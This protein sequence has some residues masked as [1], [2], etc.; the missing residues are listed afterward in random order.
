ML[1]AFRPANPASFAW[2]YG[3][4]LAQTMC[5]WVVFLYVLPTLIVSKQ[6][7]LPWDLT[8]AAQ[9]VLGGLLFALVSPIGLW[10]GYTMARD[11]EGT[12][13]PPDCPNRLVVRG[14]YS[15]VRNPMAFAGILQGGAV[16]I[17]LGSGAVVLYALAGAPVWHVIARPPEEADMRERFGE[18]FEHYRQ[19]VRLWIP[20]ARAYRADCSD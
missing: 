2:N 11:G 19:N 9:P 4:T 17:V 5:F 14:P 12:P 20:Q 18:Q 1:Q 16:G 13:L 10:A 15:Y 8:F 7:L 3:K 6:M